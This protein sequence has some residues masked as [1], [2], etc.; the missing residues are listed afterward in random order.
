MPYIYCTDPTCPTDICRAYQTGR[1]EERK[2][3]VQFIKERDNKM[4]SYW[5]SVFE[6]GFE[7]GYPV[8]WDDYK[9]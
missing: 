5:K 7:G 2:K 4:Y 3:V 8:E 6:H 9:Q 1:Q